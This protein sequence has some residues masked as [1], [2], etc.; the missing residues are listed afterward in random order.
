[1]VGTKYVDETTPIAVSRKLKVCMFFKIHNQHL[2]LN[3]VVLSF[4]CSISLN[5]QENVKRIKG[6]EKGDIGDR[7][8]LE[9][10]NPI[11]PTP[12]GAK[13]VNA[14]PIEHGTPLMPFIPKSPPP[15]GQS[16]PG[17]GDYD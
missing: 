13:N 12:G 8:S 3:I 10:Y 5:F 9:D 16:N 17:P 15:I 4:N 7:V 11:D 2:K 14:G 6:N 1:M